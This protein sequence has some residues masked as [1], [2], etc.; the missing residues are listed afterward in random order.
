MS[1]LINSAREQAILLASNASPESWF[2]YT[3][4]CAIIACSGDTHRGR[5][6][7]A[8]P[9]VHCCCRDRRVESLDLDSAPLI[10]W[11]E[12]AAASL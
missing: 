9:N 7:C 10:P 2:R 11:A 12:S 6:L 3:A 4:D 8:H 1:L 5:N